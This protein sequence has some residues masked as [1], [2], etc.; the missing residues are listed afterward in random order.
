MERNRPKPD[1][2]LTRTGKLLEI[3]GYT[4]L[5]TLW[6]ITIAVFYSSP[7]IIPIHYNLDGEPDG[8]GNRAFVFLTTG[9]AT[10]VFFI[11]TL[12][13]QVPHA[14]NYL[15]TITEANAEEQYRNAQNVLRVVRLL[16]I[17]MMLGISVQTSCSGNHKLGVGFIIMELLFIVVMTIAIVIYSTSK[18][19]KQDSVG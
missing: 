13:L 14:F 9:I 3:A 1:L 2:P 16:V 10:F 6:I 4:L 18:K 7:E 8:F 12:V 5:I 11:L 19:T 17:G 15:V